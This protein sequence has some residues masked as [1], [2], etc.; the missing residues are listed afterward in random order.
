LI[1]GTVPERPDLVA[2]ANPATYVSKTSAPMLLFHGDQDFGVPKILSE[3]LHDALVKAGAN[4]TLYIIKGAD[5]GMG[6]MDEAAV[7]NVVTMACEFFD[8][9]LRG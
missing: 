6:G 3:L 5:H 4:S 1:G 8:H 7:Q 9:H 2:R